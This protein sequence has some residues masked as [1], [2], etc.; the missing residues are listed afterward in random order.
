MSMQSTKS[1]SLPGR[2]LNGSLPCVNSLIFSGLDSNSSLNKAIR[3][4]T[5][6][7]QKVA[8]SK[9]LQ[10]LQNLQGLKFMCEHVVNC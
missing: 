4:Y 7:T 2:S 3:D 10:L 6:I 5:R 8:N 1:E 9:Y